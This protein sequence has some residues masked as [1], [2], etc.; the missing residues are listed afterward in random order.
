MTH[1][2][3]VVVTQAVIGALQRTVFQQPAFGKGHAFV[4]AA[5]VEGDHLAGAASPYDDRLAG[6]L[7]TLQLADLEFVRKAGHVPSVA[8]VVIRNHRILSRD[9]PHS[10]E[11]I[12]NFIRVRPRFRT[13]FA[14]QDALCS[15]I[16]SW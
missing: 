9:Y 6:N 12:G 13:N 15:R 16:E 11:R 4:R 1:F 7:V 10:A 14:H 3:V 5:I 2:P 8:D